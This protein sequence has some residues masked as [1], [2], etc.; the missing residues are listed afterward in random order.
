ME[1]QS[2]HTAQE[3][4][5]Y[6]NVVKQVLYQFNLKGRS[7]RK[8]PMLQTTIQKPQNDGPLVWL[9]KFS[10]FKFARISIKN[11]KN[12]IPTGK[13]TP[14]FPVG[15][16][17]MMPPWQHHNMGVLFCRRDWGT[18]QNRCGQ[19]QFSVHKDN[20]IMWIY[21]SNISRHLPGCSNLVA[22][23][24]SKWTVASRILQR[25]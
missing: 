6:H 8:K 14:S 5:Y 16:I 3:G 11:I 24:S 12:I 21:W 1:P 23:G 7:E 19:G 20:Y 15:M 4:Y 13:D 10:F 17:F 22:N 9:K 25:L 18:S 2:H